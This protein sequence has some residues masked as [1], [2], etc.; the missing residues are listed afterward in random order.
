M[1]DFIPC[2]FLKYGKGSSKIF[3]YFHANA[4]DLGKAM[5]FLSYI[6]L[7]LKMHVI[8]VEYPGYGIHQGD[9]PTADKIIADA[10]IV[11]KFIRDELFWKESDIIVCGRSIGSGPACFIASNYKPASLVL[12]SPHTS[13]RGIVKDQFMGK[14]TQ[15]LIAE[16]FRN[17]EAIAKV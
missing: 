4:E 11:Y 8:A 10:D 7:Y 12:I 13:I 9:D 14:L 6:N 16:R 5:K 17:I 2:L 1:S 3:L 15:F